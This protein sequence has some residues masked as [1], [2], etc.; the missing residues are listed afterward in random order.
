MEADA[1]MAVPRARPLRPAYTTARGRMFVGDAATVLVRFK[2]NL[3][4]KPLIQRHQ[5]TWL[6]Y[7]AFEQ[8]SS[9]IRQAML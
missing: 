9:K 6:A 2:L 3:Q 5:T 8:N 7:E 4:F 1:R